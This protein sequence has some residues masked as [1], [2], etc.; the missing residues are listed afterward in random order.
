V[1]DAINTISRRI[2][3]FSPEKK[4]QTGLGLV[5]LSSFLFS[6]SNLLV[7]QVTMS[8]SPFTVAFW[9]GIVGLLMIFPFVRFD[10]KRLT[11]HN[12]KFLLLRGILGTLSLSAF[13]SSI[14]FSSL[15]ISVGL[16]STYPIFTALVGMLFFR[17]R[18]RK[19]YVPALVFSVGGVL[20]IIRP[21]LGFIGI[22]ELLGLIAA[23]ITG[24]VLNIVRFLRET[25]SVFSIV[26]YF[27]GFTTVV[28]FLPAG[29]QQIALSVSAAL[30][31]FFIGALTTFA[32]FLMTAGY[33]YCSATGGGIVSLLGLPF[34]LLLSALVLGE[35]LNIF[36]GIGTLLVFLSG[37]LIVFAKKDA[38]NN[39][40]KG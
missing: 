9:R 36:I 25:D 28:T 22:G 19:V 3:T 20:C 10:L 26:F 24:W 27:M 30:S 11:G 2:E 7:K 8:F 6:L 18:W 4:I 1:K 38:R 12:R 23:F 15:S 33:T 5:L 21:D 35:K 13:F 16:F 39:D 32:Q 17:E 31:L 34:T 37:S 14:K 40:Q 29:P